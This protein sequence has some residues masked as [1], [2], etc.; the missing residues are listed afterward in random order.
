MLRNQV[1]VNT[2]DLRRLKRRLLEL[3]QSVLSLNSHLRDHRKIIIA[4]WRR[5]QPIEDSIK[6]AE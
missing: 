5:I 6:Q 3:S 1:E 4:F 2:Q